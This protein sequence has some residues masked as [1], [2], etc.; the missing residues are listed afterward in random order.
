LSTPKA[1]FF[2]F[3]ILGSFTLYSLKL[4][5]ILKQAQ[6][7]PVYFN[8]IKMKNFQLFLIFLTTIVNWGEYKIRPY[9]GFPGGRRDEH[10]VHPGF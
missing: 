4:F 7:I 9:K 1:I 6:P 8:S 5:A 3:S 2:N 10:C